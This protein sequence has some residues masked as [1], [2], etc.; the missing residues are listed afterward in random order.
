[1]DRHYRRCGDIIPK[2]E[3]DQL[4]DTQAHIP[5]SPAARGAPGSLQPSPASGLPI[6]PSTHSAIFLGLYST[7]SLYSTS[8]L[9]NPAVRSS[10]YSQT[11]FPFAADL[12]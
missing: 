5:R 7:I 8:L 3:C 1:M 2:Y 12:K 6:V 11:L 4:Q 9:S 10:L